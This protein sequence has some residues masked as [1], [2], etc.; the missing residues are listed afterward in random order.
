ME[1][2]LP[3][4]QATFSNWIL[5]TES[6]PLYA[7]AIAILTWL[8]TA[9]LYSI[10]ISSLKKQL[11]ADEISHSEVQNKLNSV[12]NTVQQQGQKMQ[13]EL[14]ANTEQMQ[15]DRQLFQHE[16]ERAEKL[17][18]QLSQ[19]NK[20]IAGV[21]QTLATSF[22]L[23]ERPV[24][25]MGDIKAED[26]WQQHDRVINLLSTRLRSEQQAK[27][28]LQKSYQAETERCANTEALINTL[29][30][31]LE[32]QTSQLTKLELTIEEQK[33]L[34]QQQQ[35]QAEQ[36][37]S[38]TLEKHLS[39]LAHLPELEQPDLDLV[40]AKPQ[41]TH[42]EDKITIKDTLIEEPEKAN[43]VDPVKEQ[44]QPAIIKQ[45]EKETSVEF[46]IVSPAPVVAEQVTVS[47]VKQQTGKVAEKI[48][49]LFGKSGQKPIKT[50]PVV[51]EVEQ[52][53]PT[54][55][56]APVE[57]QPVSLAKSQIGKLKNLFGKTSQKPVKVNPV[58]NE[59]KQ[60]EEKIQPV[61]VAAQQSPVST[62]KNL[63]G[64]KN[65]FFGDVKEEEAKAQSAPAILEQPPVIPAKGQ[66]GKLKSLFGKSK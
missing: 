44:V 3:I 61:S 57:Q 36:V 7:L 23:G 6:N 51:T 27:S 28:E 22:D 59:T 13:Q 52:D 56:T 46:E 1:T 55:Q 14:A 45:E 38:E 64:N 32:T 49:S 9:I 11:I 50:E 42:F 30:T 12:I 8:L 60:I 24:P 15:K 53:K 48:N 33:F 65:Y 47:P 41:I 54:I 31:V 43:S 18:Q 21:I 63:F 20:E 37:L 17:E 40:N 26:L 25:I 4:I 66:L 10:N 5:L 34:L 35:V 19:R 58:F 29:Q 39:E 62:A 2:Y 16:A